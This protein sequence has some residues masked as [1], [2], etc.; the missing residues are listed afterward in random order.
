M[1]HFFTIISENVG[2]ILKLQFLVKHR[3]LDADNKIESLKFEVT[4]SS[5]VLGWQ[6]YYEITNINLMLFQSM[7]QQT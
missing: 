4:A 1:A 7:S 5:P 3:N 6:W 2:L